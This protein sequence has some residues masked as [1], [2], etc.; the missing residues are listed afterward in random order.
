M[1]L[2]DKLSGVAEINQSEFPYKIPII[3]LTWNNQ[4]I[5]IDMF[6]RFNLIGFTLSKRY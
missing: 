1:K 3:P 6:S 4:M 5:P 2:M